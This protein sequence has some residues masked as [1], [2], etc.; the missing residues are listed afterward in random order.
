MERMSKSIQTKLIVAS[1]LSLAPEELVNFRETEDGGAI[2]IAPT[3]A[4]F[5]FTAEELAAKGLQMGTDNRTSIADSVSKV[6]KDPALS[7]SK[8]VT[9][10]TEAPGLPAD[11]VSK[12]GKGG[13]ATHPKP[14]K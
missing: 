3:G 12:K 14:K 9:I 1:L 2:A 8:G 13:S 4:K 10:E 6:K 11:S 7:S 5:K